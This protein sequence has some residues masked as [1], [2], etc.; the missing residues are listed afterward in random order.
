MVNPIRIALGIPALLLMSAFTVTCASRAQRPATTASSGRVTYA[1]V[2]S[3]FRDSCEHCHNADKAKG[4]LLMDSYEA[5]LAGGEHGAP[6]AA[7]QSASS[8]L[9]QMIEGAVTPRMPYKEDPL[10]AGQIALIRRW[11]D[12]GAAGPSAS[13]ENAAPPG[14]AA[15]DITVPAVRPVVPVTGAVA[16]LAFD[17]SARRLAVGGYEIVHVMAFEGRTWTGTLADHVDQVRA[18]AF[19]PDGR[20]L[21]AAGGPSGR[22]G[23]LKVWDLE[24]S[25]PRAVVTVRGHTDAILALAFSPDGA[26]IATASYD[27]TI[28]LWSAA[29]A[30]ELGTLKEHTDAVYAV[31]FVGN[32]Q[33][34]SAAGDRTLKVWDVSSKKRLF[35]I[36]DALDSL[37]AVAVHP[38]GTSIAAAGADRMIRTW[39]WNGE[40]ASPD[41]QT[42]TLRASTFAHGDAVLRLAYSPDGSLL[43]S[44]G[45]D[46]VI[47]VWDAGVLRER[48]ALGGQPDWV[49]GLALSPDGKWIAA[50]R[51][52]GTL[53][54]Y[55]IA[56]NGEAEQ[57]L[58]PAADLPSRNAQARS[59]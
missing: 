12:E 58:V 19:S 57:Y 53:G 9:V 28:K 2:Q 48:R 43:V 50:G 30:T 37:Y 33:L 24:A 23:E 26:T 18:V 10:T 40:A 36:N 15:G 13:A 45:A 41:G 25:P 7:G 32:S 1:Q 49:M 22:F 39:T 6:F 52:D 21:A 20:R 51:Y 47:K 46:G 5:L 4:G 14:D 31:A 55:G 3:I 17:A 59:R 27:R 11:I 54:V 8:R 35:T 38:S 56:G 29:D 44:A 34:G 42:A 16:A